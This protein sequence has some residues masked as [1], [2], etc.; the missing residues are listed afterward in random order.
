M[1]L[2]GDPQEGPRTTGVQLPSPSPESWCGLVVSG[3]TL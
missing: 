3:A 1:W 2:P